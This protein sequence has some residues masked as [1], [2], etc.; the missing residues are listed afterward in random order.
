M[1]TP[2]TRPPAPALLT[3][4]LDIPLDEGMLRYFNEY[5][6]AVYFQNYPPDGYGMWDADKRA[7]SVKEAAM[8]LVKWLDDW[9]VHDYRP[10]QSE[11]HPTKSSP[12]PLLIDLADLV[13]RLEEVE[14]ARERWKALDAKSLKGELPAHDEAERL[15]VTGICELSGPV[16][17]AELYQR[18]RLARESQ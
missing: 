9:V 6:Q 4:P 1:T 5:R 10:S 11:D 2:K 17:L 14:Q 18:V 8:S 16:L 12:A 3:L 7:A 13:A 15:R